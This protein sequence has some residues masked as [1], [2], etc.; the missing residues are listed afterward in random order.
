VRAASLTFAAVLAL[1]AAA[2][3]GGSPSFPDEPQRLAAAD[4]TSADMTVALG[5]DPVAAIGGDAGWRTPLDGTAKRMRRVELRPATARAL[6]VLAAH[7]PDAIVASPVWQRK[8]LGDRLEA[9]APTLYIEPASPA[10]SV[11]KAP[12]DA[13]AAK[14]GREERAGVVT[15]ALDSRAAALRPQ[16]EGKTVA[17]LR[18]TATASFTAAGDF[19]PVARVLADDL[20]LRNFRFRPQQYPYDCPAAPEPPRACRTNTLYAGLVGFMGSVDALLL[21][22]GWAAP[23]DVAAFQRDARYRALSAVN[24]GHV[25][26]AGSFTE[27]GPLGVAALYSAVAR[28]FG[29]DEG[30]AA[31]GGRAL[32]TTLDP[33]TSRLCWASPAAVVLVTT[34]GRVTLS[35]RKGCVVVPG[36][37]A[38]A[39]AHGRVVAQAG[40]AKAALADGPAAL[41]R[42]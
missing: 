25:A 1:A 11:W 30:H 13:L 7:H 20:G 4:A 23:S 6:A 19:V 26:E 17:V 34:A 2:C 29:L 5:L 32:S 14:L 10:G 24:A 9:V 41:V 18:I 22:T 8:G 33:S 21:E 31:L 15:A 38:S 35:A 42:R 27:L 39:L 36:A 12:L 40:A 37:V 28:A 16:V 3:G